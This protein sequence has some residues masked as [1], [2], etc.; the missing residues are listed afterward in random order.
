MSDSKSTKVALKEARDLIGTKEY[1]S[2]LKCCKRILNQDPAHLLALVF[3]GKCHHEM[4]QP[5][6]AEK[7]S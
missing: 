5:E 7:V 3:S 6:M 4:D 2:A 1:G